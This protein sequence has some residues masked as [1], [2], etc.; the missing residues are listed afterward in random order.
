MAIVPALDDTLLV[1]DTDVLTDWR[2][3]KPH[4]QQAI[5]NY[6]S[7]HGR[8]PAL[9][10][11]TVFEALKGFEALASRL[12]GLDDRAR[13]DLTA[14]EELIQS[15][16]VL[17]FDQKAAAIAA[18]SF[19]RLSQSERNKHWCDLMTVAIALSHGHG[20]AT[21]NQSDFERIGQYLPDSHPLLYLAIWKS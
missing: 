15:S 18:Y 11:I 9:T 13:K 8:L 5:R 19:A 6:L 17:P 16:D 1:L 3:R 2:Y 12:A 14:T 20:V 4:T 21:R 7:R 10:A